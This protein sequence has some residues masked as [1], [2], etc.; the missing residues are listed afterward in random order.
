MR[1]TSC[2]KRLERACSSSCYLYSPLSLFPHAGTVSRAVQPAIHDVTDASAIRSWF[3]PPM[4]SSLSAELYKAQNI[5]RQFARVGTLFPE[6]SI[7]AAVLD[8]AAGFAVL[9]VVKVSPSGMEIS[10]EV[11][12]V[13]LKSCLILRLPARILLMC[14]TQPSQLCTTFFSGVDP[15]PGISGYCNLEFGIT[16]SSGSAACCKGIPG[17]RRTGYCGCAQDMSLGRTCFC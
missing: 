2:G 10:A 15:R 11:L 4:T 9:S 13:L 14:R 1:K 17:K 6:R 5:V 3:N 8:G 16:F 12:E 7:P